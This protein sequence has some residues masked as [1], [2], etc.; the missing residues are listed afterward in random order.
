MKRCILA[1]V[2]GVVVSVCARAQAAPSYQA[3]FSVSSD[4]GSGFIGGISILNTGSTPITDWTLAFDFDRNISNLW[5]GI[6]LSRSGSRYTVDNAG[7]N[8]TIAAGQSVSFGF[9]GDPGGPPAPTNYELVLP[10]PPPPPVYELDYAIVNDWGTG[11]QAE[12]T[13]RNVGTALIDGW[14]LAFDLGRTVTQV[15]NATAGVESPG[16]P[17]FT[18]VSYTAQIAAG[19]SVSF[20]FIASGSGATPSNIRLNDVVPVPEP[21][22]A[23][24]LVAGA[25][26]VGRRRR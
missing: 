7:W 18:S 1:I 20:G 9:Q 26:L 4:W 21:V 2:V 24:W 17:S 11:F 16:R 3:T 22:L 19:S 10:A 8:G 15:W 5:D 13:I 25:L 23:P 6:I 12:V 14:T